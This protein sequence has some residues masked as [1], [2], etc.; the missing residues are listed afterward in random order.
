MRATE[1]NG[2]V[3]LRSKRFQSSY[4]AKVILFFFLLLSQL[5]RRT[6][7]GNACYAGYGNVSLADG[8]K[9]RHLGQSTAVYK[10]SRELFRP[11]TIEKSHLAADREM[12]ISSTI[13]SPQLFRFFPRFPSSIRQEI[14]LL[15]YLDPLDCIDARI[16]KVS[17]FSSCFSRHFKMAA[18]L[19]FFEWNNLKWLCI[20]VGRGHRDACVG[21]WDVETRDEGLE[22][23]N[24]GTRGRVGRGRGGR[25]M[26]MIIAKVGG[27][28]VI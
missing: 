22:D 16:F 20:K 1:R 24:Y 5:S 10:D 3:S 8:N 2:N 28:C 7:R 25:G 15:V 18:H 11:I 17:W 9:W 12:N 21:T 27:K 13:S 23:I 19:G 6:S 14:P 26:W 4:C